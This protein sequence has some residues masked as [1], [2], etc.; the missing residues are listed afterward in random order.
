MQQNIPEII[1]EETSLLESNRRKLLENPKESGPSETEIVEQLLQVR[2]DV[3]SA[4]QED[5]ATLYQQLN[6]LNSLLTQ[7]RAGRKH[8]FVDPDS[9]YF[10]HLRLEEAGK[11]RDVFLGRAT[12]LS[13]GLRIVDWRNAPISKLFYRYSEGEEYEEEIAGNTREGEVVARRVL[14]IAHGKLLRVGDSKQTWIKE[15]EGWKKLSIEQTKLAG[16]EGSS[17]RAGSTLSAH[18]GAGAKLRATKSL[19]DIA[20]LIDPEQFE[21]IT[22]EQKGV[23]VIRGSA[24]SGK[25]TVA[26]HRIAYLW[27]ENKARFRPEKVM[28]IVWGRA[29]RDYVSHVLP[30]L[31][32][33]GVKV[34]TWSQWS[35]QMVKNH[36]PILPT[37]MNQDTPDVVRRIKLHVSTERR[38]VEHVRN[39]PNLPASIEQ[40]VEDWAHV[41]TDVRGIRE[42]VSPYD[43][44]LGYQRA[45]RWLTEQTRSMSEWLEKVVEADARL[46]TEDDALLLRAYQLRVGKLR[47]RGSP[48]SL[49]HLAIDE[50]QDFSP[51]EIMVLLDICDA[52][53]CVTLAGDTRQ[54]ISQSAGFSSWQDFLSGLK[55]KTTALNTLEVSYRSTH[56]I[57]R[58]ALRLLDDHQEPPPRTTRDGPPVEFFQFSDHGACVAFLAEELRKLQ[59]AEP[60]A[61]VALLMANTKLADMYYDGLSDAEVHQVRRVLNQK[62]AFSPGIDIVEVDQVK[63]LEFD[64]VIIVEASAF[65]YPDTSHHRRLLHVAATRAVHQLWLTSCA[66]P[67]SILPKI[68]R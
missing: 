18:L 42:V 57:T 36:F 39:T 50:V 40:A 17:L 32:V 25:T 59:S 15:Q 53:Q 61:N 27:F 56:P 65:H 54:H 23:L 47:E 38:L 46:D 41:L 68:L 30:G 52:S 45:M 44:Q 31:G 24:G 63:G 2:D 9:P 55:I 14:H 49:S 29:M 34:K 26:L 28:F 19:P 4:K 7:I 16:G 35:R 51:I 20:A 1:S 8:E 58:F 21:L 67:S 64:Y 22:A 62:F 13:H 6:H 66:T 33:F 60:L 37:T 11:Q 48:I 5:L 10:A 12:R 3:N 43:D